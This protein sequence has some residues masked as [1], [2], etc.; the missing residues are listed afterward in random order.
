MATRTHA[1]T[2]GIC[3]CTEGCAYAV[4]FAFVINGETLLTRTAPLIVLQCLKHTGIL[5]GPQHLSPQHP[6]AAATMQYV[7]TAPCR[8]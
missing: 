5:S 2:R 7:S 6:A 3:R 4:R 8:R 1:A